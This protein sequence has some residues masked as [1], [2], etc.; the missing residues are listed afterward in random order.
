M[1]TAL[2]SKVLLASLYKSGLQRWDLPT[3]IINQ[4]DVPIDLPTG[5]LIEVF[6]QW[7]VL[8]SRM[9][10]AWVKMTNN[11]TQELINT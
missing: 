1:L 10:L 4:D 8:S 5:T 2:P 9:T 7:G 3:L 11:S 6:S